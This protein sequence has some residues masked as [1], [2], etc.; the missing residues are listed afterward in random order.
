MC[1]DATGTAWVFIRV[2]ART[3]VTIP[4]GVVIIATV[5]RYRCF[6]TL[7]KH[8]PKHQIGHNLIACDHV[9]AKTR[10]VAWNKH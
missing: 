2:K 3:A 10:S 9:S 4:D 6:A 7:R 8:T 1:P 5:T